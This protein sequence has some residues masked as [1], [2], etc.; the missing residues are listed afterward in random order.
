MSN[1]VFGTSV[2]TLLF[3]IKKKKVKRSQWTFPKKSTDKLKRKRKHDSYEKNLKRQREERQRKIKLF[4]AGLEP[5]TFR[6]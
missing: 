5:A 4:P 6:V 2:V 3:S 1:R